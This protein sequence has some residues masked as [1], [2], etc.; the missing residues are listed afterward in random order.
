M[1]KK[2]DIVVQ[3]YRSSGPGGQRK[4]KVET[5]VRITHV[6]TGITVHA[7]ELRSQAQNR[8]RALK[9]LEDRL[10]KRMVRRKPRVRTAV[11][12]GVIERRLRDKKTTSSKKLL[13]GKVGGDQAD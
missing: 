1:I 10:K 6:P 2:R 13:R 7:S 4:N 11:P 5:A 12:A 3:F 8:M 9:R